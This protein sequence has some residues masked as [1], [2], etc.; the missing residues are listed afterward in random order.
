MNVTIPDLTNAECGEIAI[1]AA[2]GGIGYWSQM[3]TYRPSRWSP[4]SQ[5]ELYV[6]GK[7]PSSSVEVPDTFV[8]YTIHEMNDDE[9]GYKEEGIDITP[10]VI[11]RGFEL[12][13][14]K[15]RKDLVADVLSEAREDWM[16]SI[17]SDAAEV[18]V[19]CGVLGEIKWG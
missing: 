4:D 10:V 14:T 18:I 6:K 9:D 5:H 13:I 15:A 19:Q 11:R 8:F 2:E 12:A 7:A 17:D 3:E 16:G 1:T